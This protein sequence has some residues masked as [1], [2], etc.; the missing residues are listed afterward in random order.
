[1]NLTMTVEQVHLDNVYFCD[2]IKNN[3]M[4]EGGTFV[5]ILY[6]SP[7][8]VI[9]G[10]YIAFSL[11]NVCI[12]K[13][14]NKYK[15]TFDKTNHCNLDFLQKVRSLEEFILRKAM[16]E[17]KTIQ[18]KIH[19]QLQ[20]GFIKLFT[21]KLDKNNNMFVLKISGMWETANAYG[22]TYKFSQA[23]SI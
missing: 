16:I 18:L 10:I 13:Y 1:M 17:H 8:F 14:Y 20:S 7:Y 9:N 21:D 19:E 12:E 4:N 3:V 22:L 5:R 23:L 6:S 2:P 11:S 15:C